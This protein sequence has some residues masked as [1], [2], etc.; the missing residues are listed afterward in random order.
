MRE[1][2]LTKDRKCNHCNKVFPMTA[3]Q[4]KAHAY[5]CSKEDNHAISRDAKPENDG[6]HRSIITPGSVGWG[7]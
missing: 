1:A 5:A 6:G 7:S 3:A 2:K 4:I